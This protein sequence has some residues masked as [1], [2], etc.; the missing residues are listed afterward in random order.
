MFDRNPAI[1]LDDLGLDDRSSL[2]PLGFILWQDLKAV[3]IIKIHKQ[4]II[5][6]HLQD[7]QTY[8]ENQTGYIRRLLLKTN[9]KLYGS[10]ISIS[11][12][13]LEISIEELYEELKTRIEKVHLHKN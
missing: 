4:P 7:P 5:M 2:F 8:M 6:L 3:S 9:Y 12:K 10:P 13:A 1:I 11:A